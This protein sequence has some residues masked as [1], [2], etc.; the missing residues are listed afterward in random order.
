MAA[1]PVPFLTCHRGKPA[2]AR[3]A[4]LATA[5]K[6]LRTALA[7][8][9]GSLRWNVRTAE[10]GAALFELLEAAP[11]S[12]CMLD[13]WLP[14]LQSDECAAELHAMYPETAIVLLDGSM[15]AGG[16]KS[17][18]GL[19]RQEAFHA[20]RRAQASLDESSSSSTAGFF[21]GS[22]AAAPAALGGEHMRDRLHAV[23]LPAP[24]PAAVPAAEPVRP[25]LASRAPRPVPELLGADPR[26]LEAGR[27]VGLVAGR[28]T[29]V[30]IH[31]ET[32]TGKELVAR[33]VHRLS[34]R[35]GKLVSLNCA[36]LPEALFEA[37]LF[38][39][40][41]GAFTG[42]QASRT[43]RI[44]AA[45]GGT[46]FLDE[47]GELPPAIQAKL[48]RFL[49]S[50]AIQRV[51]ENEEIRVDV[52]IIAA[53]HRKLGR[54]AQTG[55]FRLDLLHRLSVFLIQTPPLAGRAGDMDLLAAHA[56]QRFAAPGEP[57]KELA[58]EARAALHAHAWPGNVRELQHTLERAVILSGAAA[59]IER[60]A[61]DFGEA[62]C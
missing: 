43:G 7:A 38:G 18:L 32:G 1:Q 5:D 45:D 13:A 31:G 17:G 55:E 59:R 8:E 47:V 16:P 2:D 42:A 39:H 62:L 25:P 14:D 27:R 4:V 54:M 28:R 20:F 23:A 56:L 44:E 46:L 10:T 30:L 48:L 40:S 21:G 49:E 6:G 51:G 41:R 53:T 26:M 61:I 36:A 58:P 3:Q 33:A 57:A 19:L 9:L 12:V 34:G 37:E 35:K 15:E 11:A 60:D 52:R 24:G 29:P 22:P 50:G